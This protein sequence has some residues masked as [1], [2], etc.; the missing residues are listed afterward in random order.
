MRIVFVVPELPHPPFTGAH[1]RPLSMIRALALSHSVVAVGAAPPEADLTLMREL[2]AHVLPTTHEVAERS[3]RHAALST[4]RRGLSPVPFINQSRSAALQELVS[5]AVRGHQPGAVQLEGM[6]MSH[7]RDPALPAVVDLPD[8]VSS[9][10]AA[11]FAARP[12]RYA[13][14][15]AQRY[16]AARA[17]RRTLRELAAVIAI[18]EQDRARLANMGIEAIT[19]PLAIAAP[20]DAELAHAASLTAATSVPLSLLFVGS[21]LHQPNRVASTWLER[22]LAPELRRRGLPFGSRSPAGRRG[23]TAAARPG[24]TASGATRTWCSAPILRTSPRCTR[25]PTSSWCRSS[26]A[27]APRTRPSK[28]WLGRGP[29]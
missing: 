23:L 21:F 3:P 27:A 1:T 10:C 25:R 6:Y 2:C 22:R 17:E 12:L 13:F 18:N 15:G 14:A 4:L 29:S 24:F 26:T 8:V 16:G 20:S 9:L 28:P 11:A 19:V 7:Y 5:D